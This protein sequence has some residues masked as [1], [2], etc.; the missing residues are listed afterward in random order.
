MFADSMEMS[1][2]LEVGTGG[3]QVLMLLW[4]PVTLKQWEGAAEHSRGTGAHPWMLGAM[5]CTW[6]GKH[7]DAVPC[8]TLA[9]SGGDSDI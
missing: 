9:L 3:S 7:W 5:Q 8:S 1:S 6:A 4:G 2:P